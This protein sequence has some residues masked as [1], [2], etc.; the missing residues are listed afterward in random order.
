MQ[1][2]RYIFIVKNKIIGAKTPRIL[3]KLT[4]K[5]EGRVA[6]CSTQWGACFMRPRVW[7]PEPTWVCVIPNLNVVIPALGRGGEAEVRR[8]YFWGSLANQPS[9][10]CELQANERPCLKWSGQIFLRVTPIL[11]PDSPTCEVVGTYIHISSPR[12]ARELTFSYT[13]STEEWIFPW[14]TP[15]SSTSLCF[16]G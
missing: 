4:L 9:L 10:T 7:S 3:K 1:G 6:I 5:D 8:W 11:S 16:S 13:V 2:G 15:I 12:E 14:P